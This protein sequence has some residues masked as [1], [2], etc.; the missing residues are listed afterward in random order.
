MRSSSGE[1]YQIRVNLFIDERR[2]NLPGDLKAHLPAT[3]A[4]RRIRSR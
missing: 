4:A 2:L 3:P 1:P